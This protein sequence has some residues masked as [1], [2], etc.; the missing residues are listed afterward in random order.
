M[1]SSKITIIKTIKPVTIPIS[2]QEI[3]N[4]LLTN[5]EGSDFIPTREH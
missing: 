2:L 4:S 3:E 1:S 5:L